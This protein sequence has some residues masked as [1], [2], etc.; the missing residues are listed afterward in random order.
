VEPPR[1]YV[2]RPHSTDRPTAVETINED[3]PWLS[4]IPPAGS[5]VIAL[6]GLPGASFHLKAPDHG[7]WV[8]RL[9]WTPTGESRLQPK[10]ALL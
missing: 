8:R 3:R 4:H 10:H 2:Q 6:C 7:G 1:Y 5:T 9:K